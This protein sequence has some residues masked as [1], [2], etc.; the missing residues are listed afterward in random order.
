MLNNGL[1]SRIMLLT[2]IL[3]GK[4]MCEK[5]MN[6]PNYHLKMI[7]SMYKLKP[8]VEKFVLTS[9]DVSKYPKLCKTK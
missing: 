1:G 7:F 6:T 3:K 5:L 8:L 9:Q 4:T 2:G